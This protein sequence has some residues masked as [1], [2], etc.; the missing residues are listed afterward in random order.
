MARLHPDRE[1]LAATMAAFASPEV[2][3][4][5]GG[6]VSRP[7]GSDADRAARDLFAATAA[8]LGLTVRV[9]DI[10]NMFAERPGT[11]PDAL[12]V[13]IGSH[14]DTVV[15]GGRFDG[16]LGVAVALETVALLNDSGAQT[17]RP[18]IVANWTG[19]EGA[20]FPPAM[21]GSGVAVGE[22]TGEYARDRVDQ[23]GI[24]L[25]DELERIGY[26]GD[27][28]NRVG[29][30]F[31]ALEAHIEQGTVLDEAGIDVA[32]VESIETVRWYA[33]TVRGRGGHAGGP[34]PDGRAEAMVA[35]SRMVVAAR[36]AAL[37]AGDFRTTVGTMLV[38]P[39]SNNVI[40]HEVE[41]NL[42]IRSADDHRVEIVF[43]ELT[44]RFHE[45]A[46]EEGVDVQIELDWGIGGRPFD[47]ALQSVLAR[48]A[49]EGGIEVMSARGKI[50]H[51][52]S[53]L[54]LVGPAAMLFTRT[55]GGLSHCEEE[56]APWESVVATAAV[57][58]TATLAL[59]DA[60]ALPDAAPE[61]VGGAA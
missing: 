33:V 18:V 14:L 31:A 35:A 15:P 46:T 45:I 51:D 22:W 34:G 23:E 12:P 57:F 42:D 11:D 61:L 26:L 8:E 55:T 48:S 19:E 2:G 3:G 5:P 60:A 28:Q 37:A 44:T 54:A 56:H 7:A 52:S 30:F 9:D 4:T 29:A 36:D 43:A 24:R 53:H 17:L 41:F 1:R 16:I 50:G 25:G 21:V 32:V 6:G 13:L 27:E 38:D 59:A 47:G 58:A 10:G 20:R 39:G 40:P 49:A